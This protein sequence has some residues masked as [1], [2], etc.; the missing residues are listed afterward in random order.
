MISKFVSRTVLAGALLAVLPGMAVAQNLKKVTI[1]AAN[2]ELIDNLP[3]Y[4]AKEKGFFAA[5]GLTLEITHY[6]GGSEVVRPVVSGSMD[7]GFSSV[8]AAL[9]AISKGEAIK[10]VAGMTQPMYGVVWIVNGKSPYKSL[11]ELEG[12]KVGMAIPGSLTHT[13][14]ET[15]LAAE[16]MT[17]KVDVVPVGGVGDSW[18]ALKADRVQASW[19]IQPLVQSLVASGE[20]RILFDSSEY[21]KKYQMTSWVAMDEFL[22]K[23]PET[24]RKFLRAIA[25]GVD[26]IDSNPA[27]AAKI[28]AGYIEMAEGPVKAVLDG[29][30]KGYFKVAAP[31]KEH[32]DATIAD[33]IKMGAIKTAPPMDKVLDNRFLP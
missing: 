29:R 3:M 24:M 4:V 14:I 12:K 32:L 27:E 31:A 5:E 6:R 11:K 18:A 26:Y 20:A 33:V 1:A 19:H 7:I 23:E 9:I 13:V 30:P 28:A 15:A 16:K 2:K 17:G 22:K 25:K 8:S 10:I 21:I